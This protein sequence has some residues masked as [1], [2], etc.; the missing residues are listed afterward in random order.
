MSSRHDCRHRIHRKDKNTEREER[1]VP[2][3]LKG[4]ARHFGGGG[5]GGGSGGGSGGGDGVAMRASSKSHRTDLS[6]ITE[7]HR[8]SMPLVI[9]HRVG[10]PIQQSE[11]GASLFVGRRDN[12]PRSQ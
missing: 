12:W 10:N 7:N 1:R 4:T 8:A 6:R 5:G 9:R 2:H 11:F 3:A